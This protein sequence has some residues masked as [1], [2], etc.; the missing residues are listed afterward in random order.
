MLLEA[1][2][3]NGEVR[4]YSDRGRMLRQVLQRRIVAD[5]ER[6]HRQHGEREK[7]NPLKEQPLTAHANP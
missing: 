6:H 1:Q 5:P 7:Q 2:F 3:R 4:Q